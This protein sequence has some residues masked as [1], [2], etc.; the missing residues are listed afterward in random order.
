MPVCW[1]DVGYHDSVTV[2]RQRILQ[3]PEVKRQ[4]QTVDNPEAV[5]RQLVLQQPEEQQVHKT[6]GNH[7]SVAVA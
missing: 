7:G 2:A 1:R 6:V 5:A 4:H 3:Q